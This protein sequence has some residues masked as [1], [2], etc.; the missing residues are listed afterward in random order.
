MTVEAPGGGRRVPWALAV[1]FA[2][3]RRELEQT[4]A[5]LES[6]GG[7]AAVDF[8]APPRERTN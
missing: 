4:T 8:F 7:A 3:A 5:A 6:A 2:P 1:A